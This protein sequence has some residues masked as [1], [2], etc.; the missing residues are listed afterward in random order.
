LD[1]DDKFVVNGENDKIKLR[2]I[3]GDGQ[4]AFDNLSKGRPEVLVYDRAD[5]SNKLAGGFKNKMANDSF[6]NKFERIYY[7]YPY[8][9]VFVTGGFN[10]DD[11]VFLGLLSNTF[12]TALEKIL[13]NHSTSLNLNMPFQPAHFRQ[14]IWVSLSLYSAEEQTW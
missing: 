8:Q 14:I 3:G 11:G 2:L 9:S 4:D 5:G 7:K 10:P 1:G 13:I 6:V 12:D